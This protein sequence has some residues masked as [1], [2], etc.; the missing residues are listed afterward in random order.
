MSEDERV[1]A[2]ITLSEK[3]KQYIDLAEDDDQTSILLK[4][5]TDTANTFFK[6]RYC[7]KCNKEFDDLIEHIAKAHVVYLR[8]IDN[9][10]ALFNVL[11]NLDPLVKS[12]VTQLVLAVL[13]EGKTFTNSQ[14]SYIM[15]N[16]QLLVIER[17]NNDLR[18]NIIRLAAS[19]LNRIFS[20][21]TI[22]NVIDILKALVQHFSK[23]IVTSVRC[24]FVD[25]TLYYDTRDELYSIVKIDK[26]GVAIVQQTEPC[27][28]YYRSGKASLRKDEKA[29][30]RLLD[31]LNVVLKDLDDNTLSKYDTKMIIK[32]LTTTLFFNSVPKPIFC[33][34][35]KEGSGKTTL[36]N[37]I[38]KI[39]DPENENTLENET[40]SLIRDMK[41]FKSIAR[42]NYCLVFDNVSRIDKDTSD[43]LCRAST[44]GKLIHRALYTDTQQSAISIMRA[45]IITARQVP[46]YE[47]DFLDRVIV[48]KCDRIDKKDIRLVS[49][50]NDVVNLFAAV[51]YECFVTI[52]KALEIY[53][54]VKEELRVRG[55]LARL[56]DFIVLAEAVAR[57]YGYTPLE[58]TQ[59]FNEMNRVLK[60]EKIED[61][62][63]LQAVVTLIEEDGAFEGSAQ[64][65]AE[66]LLTR[67]NLVIKPNSLSRKLSDNAVVLQEHGVIFTR[68]RVGRNGKRILS[69]KHV[70]HITSNMTD[71]NGHN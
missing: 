25:N 51:R 14:E 2:F 53:N 19:T 55:L 16:N 50:L 22:N 15:I 21:N 12:D 56:A 62:E 28:P 61:D 71:N 66:L 3:I 29:W 49:E 4:E 35:G 65:L 58:F 23:H 36:A 48:V 39:I 27:L 54:Q 46:S 8:N 43:L 32:V 59:K 45:I 5:I 30:D 7:L 63:V 24:H 20:P 69:L 38:K 9:T 26:N 70:E 31:N 44:G 1:K 67:T 64:D 41:D 6:N 37:I 42:S 34:I 52:S 40:I 57:S 11:S 33:I 68:K 18:A 47:S 60:E 13:S 10:N 17:D